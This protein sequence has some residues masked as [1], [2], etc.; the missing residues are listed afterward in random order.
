M[1][2]LSSVALIIVPLSIAVFYFQ[3]LELSK[4]SDNLMWPRVPE[5]LVKL[6][7]AIE[8]LKENHFGLIFSFWVSFFILKQTF[9][10]PGSALLNIIAGRLF[11]VPLALGLVCT[12]TTIGASCCY[13]LSDIFGRMLVEKCCKDKL[14]SFKSKIDENR[15][16]LFW[17]LVSSRIFPMTPN[18]FLNLASPL[19]GVPYGLFALSIFVGLIPYNLVCVQTGALLSE[20]GNNADVNTILSFQNILQLTV[21]ALAVLSV[22]FLKNK[23]K[24]KPQKEKQE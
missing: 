5:D 14:D 8:D 10:M 4:H 21:L 19:V 16:D 20:F 6:N 1:R 7:T 23:F 15:D 24:P 22:V 13:A 12:M 9:S 17:Y 2:L 3:F 11:G 18:W